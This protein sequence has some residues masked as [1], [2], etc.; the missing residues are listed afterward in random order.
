MIMRAVFF[1][2]VLAIIG[3]II[4]GAIQLQR[5]DDTITIEIH[6]SRVAQDAKTVVN[7]GKTVL[8]KAEASLDE[9]AER[10]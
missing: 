1:L 7:K 4:T 5:T 3:L 2:G 8:R 10:Q 9:A 6:K